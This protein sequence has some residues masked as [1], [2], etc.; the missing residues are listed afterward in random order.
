MKK[1]FFAGY[2]M[3]GCS[4]TTVP[5]E[6]FESAKARLIWFLKNIFEAGAD[7][8]DEA[9]KFCFIAED[10][11]LWSSEYGVGYNRHCF[12]IKSEELPDDEAE[13]LLEGE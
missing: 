8:E 4:P 9:G 2:N 12:F 1:V 5:C 6:N 11:N 3:L 7:T 10:V 13:A